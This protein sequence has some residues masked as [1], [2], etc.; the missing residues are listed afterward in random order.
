MSRLAR[1]HLLP[2]LVIGTVCVQA[3]GGAPVAR[4]PVPAPAAFDVGA[5]STQ[6]S[7]EARALRAKGPLGLAEALQ[8]L[9]QLEASD[10]RRAAL[11]RLVDDVAQQRDAQTTR[12]YWYTDLEEAKKVSA[13]A[14]KPILSLRMLGSLTDEFSCANSRFFRAVLYPDTRIRRILEE[15][16]VLHWSSERPAP[17]ITIDFR[18]GRK[19]TRT[20]TGNSIHYV[21]GA[22][23]EP[24]DALPGLVSQKA[25]ADW[26]DVTKKLHERYSTG[27]DAVVLDYHRAGFQLGSSSYAAFAS[28]AGVGTALPVDAPLNAEANQPSAAL[29]IPVA[30]GKSRVETPLVRFAVPKVPG[31]SEELTALE[32]VP[33]QK[34]AQFYKADAVLSPEGVQGLRRKNPQNWSNPQA[35]RNLTDA[36]FQAML[37]AFQDSIAEDTAKNTLGLHTL[38]HSWFLGADAPRTFTALN[39]KVYNTLFLTP[40]SDP[41]LGLVPAR[42]FSGLERDGISTKP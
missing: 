32:L 37:T 4:E 42:A 39:T 35:P 8:R 2:L 27:G 26:L 20:I 31:E 6:L 5:P 41:W 15:S 28:R 40:K 23:G 36:E 3:C 13:S 29:A 21:L 38:I 9:D 30:I 12:L 34:F 14:K 22:K 11:L 24:L 16:F 1:A 7:A 17:L 33:W 18:D 10:P 25:F 19:V